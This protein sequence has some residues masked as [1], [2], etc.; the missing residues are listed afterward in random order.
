MT[1]LIASSISTVQSATKAPR[2]QAETAG[3]ASLAL[4]ASML[5][6]LASR[7]VSHAGRGPLM[8]IEGL[9]V[10]ETVQ[11]V[12]WASMLLLKALRNVSLARR[13]QVATAKEWTITTN[14]L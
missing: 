9:L 6:K 14:A 3:S 8:V 5:M 1:R 7:F 10:M 2:V 12:Q 13:D 4:Q 11:R